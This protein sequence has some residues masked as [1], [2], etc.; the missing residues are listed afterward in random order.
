MISI[1]FS[2]F[3]LSVRGPWNCPNFS[4]L[5]G[6]LAADPAIAQTRKE[7]YGNTAVM[8]EHDDL[9]VN[10]HVC[11]SALKSHNADCLNNMEMLSG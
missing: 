11:R 9:E 6:T 7:T 4:L 8:E 1:S 5:Y 10:V 3:S 2:L